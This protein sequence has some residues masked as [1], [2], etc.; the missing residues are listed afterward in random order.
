MKHFPPPT[1]LL[2]VSLFTFSAMAQTRE[3]ST[4]K[5]PSSQKNPPR[6]L[7]RYPKVRLRGWER[8]E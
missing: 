2:L 5:D 7:D 6:K 1:V 3:K 4:S 8:Y